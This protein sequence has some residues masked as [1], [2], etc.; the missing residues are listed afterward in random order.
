MKTD[1]LIEL[2]GA[3]GVEPV[4]GRPLRAALVIALAVGTAA[5][6][7]VMLAALGTPPLARSAEHWD[8]TVLVTVFALALVAT[9]SSFL[10]AA[11]R[12]AT[13]ARR[14]L[15]VIGLLM[16]LIPCAAI[17]A[18]LEHGPAGVGAG[19]WGP[20]SATCLTCIPLFA[21]APFAALV[22][23]LRRAA[24]TSLRLTG[25]VAGVVSGA[26]GA[27]ACALHAPDGSLPLILVWY[28]AP[29]ILTALVG[30]ALGPRLLRW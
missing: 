16:L 8:A 9:G 28:G 11:M 5:A 15:E 21:I 1:E 6:F 17:A 13:I 23:V 24:P 30:A 22:W 29:I 12:P 25:A 18:L 27:A 7:C 2:L 10:L 3:G 4:R 26:L 14:T 20:Q 19:I